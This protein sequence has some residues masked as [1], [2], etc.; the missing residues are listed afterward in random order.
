MSPKTEI[1]TVY[2]FMVQRIRRPEFKVTTDQG[3]VDINITLELNINLNTDGISVSAS[4]SGKKAEK[5][6][7]PYLVP[8]FKMNKVDFGKQVKE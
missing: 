3:E 7:A 1:V 4:A 8:D 5:D 2:I 6:D